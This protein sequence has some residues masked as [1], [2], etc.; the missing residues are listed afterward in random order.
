ME[1]ILEIKPVEVIALCKDSNRFYKKGIILFIE[2]GFI[3]YK[4]HNVTDMSF[5]NL[6]KEFMDYKN[7]VYGNIKRV[8]STVS[9]FV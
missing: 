9:W 1:K 4:I 7:I 3:T 6:Q 2:N 5:E 8:L